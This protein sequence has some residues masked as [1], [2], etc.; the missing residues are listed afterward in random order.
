MGK[1]RENNLSGCLHVEMNN[2]VNL[3]VEFENLCDKG[4]PKDLLGILYDTAYLL[5]E[6]N[7]VISGATSY[8][9]KQEKINQAS[10][11]IFLS[12][13][14][15]CLLFGKRGIAIERD[16]LMTERTQKLKDLIDQYDH[17]FL[18]L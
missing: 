10:S 11:L 12:V 13:F 5:P 17:D 9:Y 2:C 4:E 7:S 16:R 6:M 8:I 1:R 15:Y 3:A 18:E 14:K